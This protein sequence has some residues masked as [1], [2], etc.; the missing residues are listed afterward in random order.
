M[1]FSQIQ[2]EKQT[3]NTKPLFSHP[4]FPSLFFSLLFIHKRRKGKGIL[5]STC[6]LA[7]PLW[8]R[9]R[10][11]RSPPVCWG[12]C[13]MFLWRPRLLPFV[14]PPPSLPFHSF[15][16]T[17]TSSLFLLRHRDSSPLLRCCFPVH[18]PLARPSSLAP[19]A[20]CTA[21]RRRPWWVPSSRRVA[22]VLLC[23]CPWSGSCVDGD[24][25]VLFFHGGVA[26]GRCGGAGGG[27]VGGVRR[28]EEPAG[29][30][31][32]ARQHARRLLRSW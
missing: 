6:L 13:V 29:G 10:P 4:N 30:A 11:C 27:E 16:Y 18:P 9:S 26:G 32:P 8:M 14:P 5:R 12:L 1:N 15:K 7:S 2:N 19:G 28:L 22:R 31:R 17:T 25:W 3:R 21:Y 23:L 24:E 20:S